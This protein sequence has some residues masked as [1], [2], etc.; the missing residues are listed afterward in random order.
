LLKALFFDN[1][2]RVDRFPSNY[3]HK[4]KKIFIFLTIFTIT[5]TQFCKNSTNNNIHTD[6]ASKGY[7]CFADL[8]VESSQLFG[9]Y[10]KELDVYKNDIFFFSASVLVKNRIFFYKEFNEY[11]RILLM[12]NILNIEYIE[13]YNN[14]ENKETCNARLSFNLFSNKETQSQI[15]DGTVNGKLDT[16]T[17]INADNIKIIHDKESIRSTQTGFICEDIVCEQDYSDYESLPY[18]IVLYGSYLHS[19]LPDEITIYNS[20]NDWETHFPLTDIP[21]VDF[22]N[23]ILVGIFIIFR[24]AGFDTI[25]IGNIINNNEKIIVQVLKIDNDN[26]CGILDERQNRYA[27]IRMEKMI[28]ELE[29]SLCS[30]HYHCGWC[31]P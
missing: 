17:E 16:F 8:K 2:N 28:N 31:G 14:K 13:F 9:L 5:F 10:F 3:M 27:I 24:D 11:F 15:L 21:Q 29:I 20:T 30:Q 7:G 22:E 23:E 4:G 26:S 12:P 19:P 1:N 6:N 25:Q 18:E